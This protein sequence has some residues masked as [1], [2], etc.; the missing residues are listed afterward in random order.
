MQTVTLNNGVQMPILGFGVFQIPDA[1]ECARCVADAIE[2]GYRLIDIR[3]EKSIYGTSFMSDRF[4]SVNLQVT[5]KST[6]SFN[7]SFELD[8]AAKWCLL[9]G[10]ASKVLK[11]SALARFPKNPPQ[12]PNLWFELYRYLPQDQYESQD[13]SPRV[14]W[15]PVGLSQ[16]DM[17]A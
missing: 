8:D 16:T 11:K 15:R 2:V 7:D 1:N 5:Q 13:E 17:T 14:S 3:I 6:L 10:E 4:F 9:R 12:D